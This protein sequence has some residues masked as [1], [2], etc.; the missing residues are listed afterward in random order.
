MKPVS[1]I[2]TMSLQ[3]NLGGF[4]LLSNKS[5][6][7]IH[8]QV[9][10]FR[11]IFTNLH[12]PAGNHNREKRMAS[13]NLLLSQLTLV[14]HFRNFDFGFLL[15]DFNFRTNIDASILKK[16]IDDDV[17]DYELIKKHDEFTQFLNNSERN[18]VVFI[19]Q[20][21]VLKNFKKLKEAEITFPPSYKYERKAN[22][23][24]LSDKHV[25][26]YTDRIFSLI[27]NKHIWIEQKSYTSCFYLHGS[28]HK[29][30]YAQYEIRI[31]N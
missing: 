10:G 20:E 3:K 23:Y 11:I 26:S 24:R 4:G 7:I 30:I 31:A 19:D 9:E 17:F 1:L 29:P 5:F 2:E 12:F 14:S 15:G 18:D 27:N 22:V 25:P 28:D 21:N 6:I 8:L 13:L 16:I